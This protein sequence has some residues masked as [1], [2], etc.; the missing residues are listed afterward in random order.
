MKFVKRIIEVA[1]IVLVIS[2]F[3]KNKDLELQINYF[4]LSEPIRMAFWE[5]VTLCVSI[6]I[7]IAAAGDLVT[8]LKWRRE[9]R[10]MIR[11][12][13]ESKGEMAR[14]TGLVKGLEAEIDRLRKESEQTA[15]EPPSFQSGQPYPDALESKT[16]PSGS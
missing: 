16:S 9:R 15:V 13:Q 5:L 3:M 10:K 6:G 11:A 7:I 12:E 4:G 8:Q 2:I 1:F 14:L